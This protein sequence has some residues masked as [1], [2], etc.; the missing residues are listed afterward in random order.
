MCA[1]IMKRAFA[2]GDAEKAT[3]VYNKKCTPLSVILSEVRDL[4]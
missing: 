1:L 4:F 2:R 3:V